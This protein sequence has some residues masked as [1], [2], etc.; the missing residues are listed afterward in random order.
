VR[1]DGIDE[2]EE[3]EMDEDQVWK[4]MQKSSGFAA[5]GLKD[6]EDEEEDDEDEVWPS[7]DAAEEDDGSEPEEVGSD[8][9]GL[10]EGS[11]DDDEMEAWGKEDEED[12]DENAPKKPIRGKRSILKMSEKAKQLGF[13]GDYFDKLLTGKEDD[14]EFDDDVFA[15]ADDFEGL[16]DLDAGEGGDDAKEEKVMGGKRKGAFGRRKAG[17]KTQKIR[18]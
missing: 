10:L 18:R 4:A 2:E 13:T 1:A 15:Q 14:G 7:D 8:D 9:G 16:V 12:D 11:D 17:K 3:E 5:T 6:D